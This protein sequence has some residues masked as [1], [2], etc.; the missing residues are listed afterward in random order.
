MSLPLSPF[1]VLIGGGVAAVIAAFSAVWRY[2]QKLRRNGNTPGLRLVIGNTSISVLVF[3]VF[4]IP[5][6]RNWEFNIG[7]GW[8]IKYNHDGEPVQCQCESSPLD[9]QL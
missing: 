1:T 5:F 9:A 6:T 4:R 7:T 2:Q 8:G 3:P